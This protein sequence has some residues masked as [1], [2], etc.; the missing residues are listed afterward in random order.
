MSK[1][2]KLSDSMVELI[3][4]DGIIIFLMSIIT[5]IRI[6]SFGF[7]TITIQLLCYIIV[8]MI[9]TAVFIIIDALSGNLWKDDNQE[10]LNK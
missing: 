8:F 10:N 5:A 1:A 9:I 3:V 4:I 7:D 6:I 2:H